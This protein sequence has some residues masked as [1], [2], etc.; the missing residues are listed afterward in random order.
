MSR[1]IALVTLLV[2]DYDEAIAFY[3]QALRFELLE[4]SPQGEGKRWV[5]VAP[6]Q[7]RGAA[8]LL[9]QADSPEQTAQVGSQAGGRVGFFLH[10]ADFSEDYNHM[11]AHGVRFAEEPRHEPYGVVVVFHDL[12]GN[13][14]DL[15]QPAGG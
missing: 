5:I 11:Q 7:S 10:T 14:W 8:L 1:S 2:H 4:D 3:T 6:P 13:K 9:A 15:L 12:Y